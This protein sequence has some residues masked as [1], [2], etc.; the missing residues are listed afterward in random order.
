MFLGRSPMWL[1]Y[2][3]SYRVCFISTLFRFNFISFAIFCPQ[4]V[5]SFCQLAFQRISQNFRLHI[6][7]T[8]IKNYII[9]IIMQV[10]KYPKALFIVVVPLI[11]TAEI[12]LCNSQII[13]A[14]SLHSSSYYIN[15]IK[16][17]MIRNI[18][19]IVDIPCQYLINYAYIFYNDLHYW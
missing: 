5:L 19:C 13:L 7:R 12:S 14:L 11:Y 9:C 4:I 16:R 8:Y 10:D 1:L 3:Y 2:W 18:P 15:K 17:Q 6:E